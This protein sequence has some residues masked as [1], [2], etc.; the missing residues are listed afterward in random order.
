MAF[1]DAGTGT[2]DRLR[3]VFAGEHAWCADKLRLAADLP[4]AIPLPAFFEAERFGAMLDRFAGAR[5]A[6]DRRVALSFWSLYYFSALAIP[7]VVAR[8]AGWNLPLQLDGMTIALDDEDLPTAFGLP[9]EGA[10]RP[11]SETPSGMLQPLVTMHLGEAVRLLKAVGG[12]A[13]KLAWNN[14]AVYVDYAL[15]ATAGASAAGGADNWAAGELFETPR[16]AD[17]TANP[18]LGCLRHEEAGGIRHCRRKVC[19]LRYRLPGVPGCGELCALPER[20]H[21]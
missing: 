1:P 9:H 12:L 8:R 14:A 17:G 21:A 3:A 6:D 11:C 19:C 18:F 15:K 2:A 10:P 4:G 5:G 7:F 13:P 20:R 16:F